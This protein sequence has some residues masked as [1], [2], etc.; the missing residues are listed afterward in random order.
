[1]DDYVFLLRQLYGLYDIPMC[2]ISN[3]GDTYSP[4]SEFKDVDPLI[5][6][7]NL[8]KYLI[9]KWNGSPVLE[10]EN[11]NILY[12]ICRDI[13]ETTCI[14]GPVALKTLSGSELYQ[15]KCQHNLLT[16]N[17]YKVQYGSVIRTASALALVH[18]KM[19]HESIDF[20]SIITQLDSNEN[21]HKISE[22]DIYQYSLQTTE[23]ITD[24]LPYNVGNTIISAIMSGDI[25]TL[26]ASWLTIK[27]EHIGMMANTPLKQTEYLCVTGIAM[28]SRAAMKGGANPDEACN[29]SDLYLQK[30]SICQD[31]LEMRKLMMNAQLALCECVIQSKSQKHGLKFIDECKEYIAKNLNHQITLDDI[32]KTVGFSRCYLTTQFTQQEGKSLKRYIHEERI[33]AAQNML[34]FSDYPLPIIANYFCFD[35]QSHFGSVFK[36]ITGLTPSA[37]RK[38]N[39]IEDFLL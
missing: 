30:I 19:N 16:Y 33:K 7:E 3:K 24:F 36:K 27:D 17:H 39:Y 10:L 9:S 15:Y 25:N 21:D 34:R 22:K 38:L 2:L 35:S 28:F 29:I 4:A 14:V 20:S 11:G 6:D 13:H 32:S 8:A 1:M 31:E 18:E 26:K 5:Q 12:G 37:Y 23:Q